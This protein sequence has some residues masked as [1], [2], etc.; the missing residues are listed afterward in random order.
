MARKYRNRTRAVNETDPCFVWQNNVK[1]QYCTNIWKYNELHF[2]AKRKVNMLLGYN[3]I[4][5]TKI[6]TL[7]GYKE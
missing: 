5:S 7:L 6:T 1:G 3:I 4:V 2:C